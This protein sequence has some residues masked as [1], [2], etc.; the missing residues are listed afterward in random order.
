LANLVN[1]LVF[2]TE[3]K[4]P[5]L[6]DRILGLQ[7]ISVAPPGQDRI[8]GYSYMTRELLWHGMIVSTVHGSGIYL[9]QI[10][11]GCEKVTPLCPGA[12]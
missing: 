11:L 7:P 2:L 1:L 4:H 6:V 10:I 5:T 8:V 9:I 3:G 12:I